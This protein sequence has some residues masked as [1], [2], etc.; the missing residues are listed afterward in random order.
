M[1]GPWQKPVFKTFATA[2][3]HTESDHREYSNNALGGELHAAG[4]PIHRAGSSSAR[5][6]SL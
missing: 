2:Y 1:N 4:P 5:D 6:P 3:T